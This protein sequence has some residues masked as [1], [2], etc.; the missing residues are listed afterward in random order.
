MSPW[1]AIHR[2]GAAK[3]GAARA[4]APALATAPA[5]IDATVRR[6]VVDTLA[7][8][9]IR[10]YVDADTGM[11]IAAKMRARLGAGAYD[12]IT[13][14]GRFAEALTV[15]L[16][17]IND[18]RHLNVTYNPEQPGATPGPQG[19]QMPAVLPH[20]IMP[21]GPPPT[22]PGADAARRSNYSLGRVDILPGNVGYMDIRGFS[23]AQMVIPAIKS[24]LEYLQGT[25]AIVISDEWQHRGLG[26]ELLERLVQIGRDERVSAIVAD[27]LPENADMRRICEKVGF[28]LRYELGD[29]VV[30]ALLPWPAAS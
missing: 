21:S 27:I 9:L 22:G 23:G 11:L 18:D 5:R 10:H 19:L 29:S 1:I 15:D 8:R 28:K 17:S 25:D 30:R 3:P 14:P 26:T 7:A 2:F 12:R 13:I 6:S 24:A 20:P 4:Q 16:R